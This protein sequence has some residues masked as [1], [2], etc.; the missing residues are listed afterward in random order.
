MVKIFI[1]GLLRSGPRHGYAMKQVLESG[2]YAYWADILPNSIYNAL[3]LL[4]KRGFIKESQ[5]EFNGKQARVSYEITPSGELEF[6][7]LLL[8]SLTQHSPA[9]PSDLY[10]ALTHL[11]VL[12]ENSVITALESR[13]KAIDN[14][15]RIWENARTRKAERS[16]VAE[17]MHQIFNN[18]IS[19]LKSD[20]DLIDYLLTNWE[21]I[22]KTLLSPENRPEKE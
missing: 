7:R 13:R 19:H 20:Y 4:E 11:T 2:G 22:R 18:G 9:L 16:G 5:T 6:E 8:S 21:E 17:A 10:M 12:P 1:L 15:I 14:E 3:R